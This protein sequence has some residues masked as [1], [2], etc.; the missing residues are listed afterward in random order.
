M[1]SSEVSY[2]I[3]SANAVNEVITANVSIIA[4]FFMVTSYFVFMTTGLYKIYYHNEE[5]GKTDTL[6]RS[7]YDLERTRDIHKNII[8]MYEI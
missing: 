5:T 4:A 8:T 6:I 7:K 3:A 1:I 2:V